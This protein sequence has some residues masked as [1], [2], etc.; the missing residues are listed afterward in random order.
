MN[1]ED[2]RRGFLSYR[3]VQGEVSLADGGYCGVQAFA[4]LRDTVEKE[5]MY[6]TDMNYY[7]WIAVW[8]GGLCEI[9]QSASH[10]SL[11]YFWRV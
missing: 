4:L 11:Q 5:G 10:G 6:E 3:S 1:A 8:T 2:F 7:F 9:S